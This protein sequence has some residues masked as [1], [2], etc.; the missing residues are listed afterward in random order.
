MD[1]QD[2]SVVVTGAGGFIGSHLTERL[3]EAGALVR[4]MVHGD[5][6]CH[7][8]HLAA[9][10]ARKPAGL[11]L[12]GGDLTDAEFMRK[13]IR[14]ADTVFHLAAVT[15]VAYSYTHPGETMR[16]NTM[17]TLNVCT[18]ALEAGVRRLVHTSTAGVYGDAID[19]RPITEAHPLRACNPYTAGKLGGDHVADSFH[20]SYQL[21]VA[22]VRLFN[23]IGPRMGRY[24][25]IPTVIE[26]LR[27][28]P[29]LRLGDLRPTRTFVYV[30][31]I[32]DAYLRMA[33]HDAVTGEVVHF[34]GDEEISMRELVERIAKAMGTSCQIERDPERLRPAKSEIFRVYADTTKARNLLGWTPSIGLDA[35]LARIIAGDIA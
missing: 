13:T 22:T 25:I 23:T 5:P 9:C 2:T 26:Q 16:T 29:V 32:V 6:L 17:G 19:G 18:G 30:D 24:L 1:W 3:L 7:P 33:T 12:V 28:G 20:R 27:E 15:S 34:G 11:E 4:A 14:G 10:A 35:G 31:D 8:G 21:P